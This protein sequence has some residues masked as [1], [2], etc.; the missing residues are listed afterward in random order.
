MRHA[1]RGIAT[2]AFAALAVACAPHA[3]RAGTPPAA[4]DAQRIAEQNLAAARLQHA[5]IWEGARATRE[6]TRERERERRERHGR[7]GRRGGT[8][9]R[10]A[11]PEE[12]AV[13]LPDDA[14]RV[15]ARPLAPLHALGTPANVRCNDPQG[16]VDGA[17]QSEEAVAAIGDHVVVAWNDGQGLSVPNGDWIG[18]AWSADG[19]HTYVD[20][21]TPP[22]PPG[23][24]TFRWY[25]DPV[26]AANAKTGEF[27]L[28]ALGKIDTTHVGVVVSY[29]H[30]T[31]GTFAFDGTTIVRSEL[32]DS[33]FLDKPWI[34]CDSLAG[35][36]ALAYTAFGT[37]AD[38]IDFQR[39]LDGGR[40]WSMPVAISSNPDA[41]HVQGAWL[42][43]GPDGDIDATWIAIHETDAINDLRFR[44]ST[45][46]GASFG[47]QS[48]VA[49]T[50]VQFGSGGPGF[51]RAFGVNLP[52]LAV[53]DSDG[54]HRGRIVVAWPESWAFTDVSLP[55]PGA[56]DLTESE[57]VQYNDTPTTA[58]P[59]T[60]GQTLRGVLAPHPG[61]Q[62]TVFDTDLFVTHLDAGQSLI[63][64][65]DSI[66]A[67]SNWY[68]RLLA[69]RDFQ[70][71]CYCGNPFG[72]LPADANQA[73]FTFTAPAAGTYYLGLYENAMQPIKYRV[74]T[75]IGSPGGERGRDQRDV[76]A[77]W[78]DDG[79]ATWSGPVRVND[80]PPGFDEFLPAIGAG[81]DGALYATWF[82]HRADTY[83]TRAFAEIT[84]SIDGGATW[85]PNQPLSEM[86]SNF[87]ASHSNLSPNMGD[88]LHLA[89]SADALIPVWADGRFYDV[90][91][92]SAPIATGVT[93]TAVPRDTVLGAPGTCAWSGALAHA[94]P[95]WG[96]DYSVVLTEE[97]GWP[98]TSPAIVPLTAGST[99]AAWSLT[100]DVP[101]TAALGRDRVTLAV[102]SPAGA[103]LW[104]RTFA[105]DVT[106]GLRS[107]S[108]PVLNVAAPNP[109]REQA[110]LA[111]SLPRAGLARLDVYDVTGARVR[112]L[113]DRACP[114]GG[115]SVTWDGRDDRG[116]RARSGVYFVRLVFEGRG[117]SSRLVLT[118]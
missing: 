3:A 64:F 66:G 63:V 80:D 41:G 49:R 106:P 115:T 76:F 57:L 13:P 35:V 22:P 11:A 56:T 104:R 21:G 74:R 4:T 114:M 110:R 65:A 26:M 71:L 2:V 9:A 8:H 53:D 32:S 98:A 112:K 85:A 46:H 7:R 86:S 108:E 82:D 12:A 31:G 118:R 102:R 105:I 59:F 58:T 25:S 100:L 78:S 103:T 101:D 117:V 70:R 6:E 96:G 28:S 83:G 68:V 34:A 48:T 36:L 84:R 93:L 87:T 37:F 1:V 90:D 88:Y 109:V 38:T 51:S 81:S 43:A 54:P 47:P 116:R 33:I 94:N 67:L 29:G 107:T 61:T 5:A 79:G 77:A 99:A 111:F 30:F 15:L 19:G 60:A 10:P 97:R 40:T 20:G 95:L 23:V 73:Y 42:A 44:R 16:D 55:Q 75:A 50:H 14:R 17:G 62:G 69:P 18:F 39:S 91:V 92:W 113:L 89:S 24:P 27:F 52:T 45:D 72:Q